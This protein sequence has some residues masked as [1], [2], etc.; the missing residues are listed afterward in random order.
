MN[1]DELDDGLSWRSLFNF[2]EIVGRCWRGRWVLIFSIP[3]FIVLGIIYMHVSE[4][5]YT[6]KAIVAPTEDKG[7]SIQ[8]MAGLLTAASPS[9]GGILGSSKDDNFQEFLTLL[10]SHRLA[11]RIVEREG[12]LQL[13]FFDMWDAKNKQWT[14]TPLSLIK[15][16]IREIL[17]LKQKVNPAADDVH[18]FLKES[19]IIK[20]SFQ[21]SLVEV[22][23]QFPDRK[24]GEKI[25]EIMLSEADSIIR[26]SKYRDVESRLSYLQDALLEITLSE[27]K[28]VVIS[29]LS[30]QQNS[31]MMIKADARY[32]LNLVEAPYS[33]DKPASPRL[34]IV[35]I[36][37]IILA[38]GT[39]VLFSVMFARQKEY[40]LLEP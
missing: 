23:Y 5:S 30:A 9:L 21:N 19:V 39:W 27:Q 11:E 38:C 1:I 26:E 3:A 35:I 22:M 6:I 2:Q 14:E 15:N 36:I 16:I 37:S 34:P 29:M 25:L 13:L 33:L 28:Q 32:A 17:G 24:R 40:N 7:N 18:E 31:M 12:G 10:Q 4:R 20:R 8:G